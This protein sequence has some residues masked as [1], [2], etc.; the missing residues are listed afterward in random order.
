GDLVRIVDP[1]GTEIARGLSNY[2]A[3]EVRKIAGAHTRQISDI[4]GHVGHDEV[5]HR[6]NMVMAE[7]FRPRG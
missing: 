7:N 5:V 2:G 1:N 4:L 3:D 6:D